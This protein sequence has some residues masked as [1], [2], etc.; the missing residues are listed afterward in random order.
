MKEDPLPQLRSFT[1]HFLANALRQVSSLARQPRY[2]DLRLA[3]DSIRSQFYDQVFVDRG[4]S[5]LYAQ[6]ARG[7]HSAS[8]TSGSSSAEEAV[9]PPCVPYLLGLFTV[10]LTTYLG[11][12]CT[13]PTLLNRHTSHPTFS[14]VPASAPLSLAY[15]HD[16]SRFNIVLR[17]GPAL[18]DNVVPLRQVA[19]TLEVCG[20]DLCRRFRRREQEW[21]WVAGT[22]VCTLFAV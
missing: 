18:S 19:D 13:K 15:N 5:I 10:Q 3:N 22:E 2:H 8:M 6:G 11:V 12:S 14:F 9:A 20:A 7:H 1:S 21:R 4:T 17:L 16:S